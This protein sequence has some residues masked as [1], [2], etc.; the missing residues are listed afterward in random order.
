VLLGGELDHERWDIDH[1]LA[2]SDVSLSDHDS[3]VMDTLGELVSL[4]NNG[5]KSSE[6][7]LINGKTENVIEGLLVFLH[8]TELDD[9]SDEGITF[10]L[11]SWVVLIKSHEFSG[12]LSKL[13]EGELDSPHFSL[14]FET[15]SSDNLELSSESVLVERLSWG[16]RSFL[17]VCVFS[18]HV[19]KYTYCSLQ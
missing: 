12:S 14:V 16:L 17:V 6:H 7:E 2:N 1:L 11:S 18:W 13:G 10:E 5:L 15:V 9:S 3:S 8:E 19:S 4:G